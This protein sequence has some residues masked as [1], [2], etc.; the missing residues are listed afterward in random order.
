M[1]L[2]NE[3]SLEKI[4]RQL[5]PRVE[6]SMLPLQRHR[7]SPSLP[8]CRFFSYFLANNDSTGCIW[9]LEE[10]RLICFYVVLT[11]WEF[12]KSVQEK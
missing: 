10:G 7:A 8:R 1:K 2:E 4:S 12:H 9:T 5:H 6:S 11:V 3:P